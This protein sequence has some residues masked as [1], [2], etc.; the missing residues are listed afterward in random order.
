MNKYKILLSCPTYDGKA[1]CLDYWA[2]NVKK[3]QK[4][5]D[6]KQELANKITNYYKNSILSDYVYFDE[7]NLSTIFVLDGAATVP[8]NVLGKQLNFGMAMNM[9]DVP[10]KPPLKLIYP[11]EILRIVEHIDILIL[12][13]KKT[14]IGKYINLN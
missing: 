5:V 12:E 2:E 8:L 6:K 13:R 11:D 10:N 9:A 14:L 7:V 3:L 1:Y 4:V